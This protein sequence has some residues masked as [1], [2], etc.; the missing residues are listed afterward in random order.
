MVDPSNLWYRQWQ[1]PSH[2]G[3]KLS[4]N[5]SHK[6]RYQLR[7]LWT[8]TLNESITVSLAATWKSMKSPIIAVSQTSSLSL[9]SNPWLLSRIWTTIR[10]S[11]H[12]CQ[13]LWIQNSLKILKSAADMNSNPRTLIRELTRDCLDR[14]RIFPDHQGKPN[15]TSLLSST[16]PTMRW[17]SMTLSCKCHT[18]KQH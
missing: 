17:L 9:S 13:Q 6:A 7:R 16:V 14:I 10:T 5:S 2:H 3:I 8:L 15:W 11:I 1:V 4:R 18:C 12:T